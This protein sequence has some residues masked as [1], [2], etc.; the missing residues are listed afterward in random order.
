MSATHTLEAT[1]TEI[2][3]GLGE[4]TELSNIR[5]RW[6]IAGG[7]RIAKCDLVGMHIKQHTSWNIF[8]DDDADPALTADFIAG[9]VKG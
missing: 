1:Y 2:V 5:A 8:I 4:P 7:A 6:E 3:E 9:C